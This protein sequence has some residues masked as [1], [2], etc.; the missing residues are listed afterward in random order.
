[1]SDQQIQCDFSEVRALEDGTF[2]HVAKCGLSRVTTTDQPY[3]RRCS[4]Q[5]DPSI[6]RQPRKRGPGDDMHDIFAVLGHGE[7]CLSCGEHAA[8]MN[9]WGIDGC[10]ANRDVII[11]WLK[12]SAAKLTKQQQVAIYLKA[13]QLGIPLKLRDR[14]GSLVDEAIRRAEARENAEQ[15]PREQPPQPAPD[16]GCEQDDPNQSAAE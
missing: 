3:F 15:S 10:R 2:L 9:A 11:G 13:K 12:E 8:Q 6:I 5:C 14:Y 7:M 4:G 16:G 1:M